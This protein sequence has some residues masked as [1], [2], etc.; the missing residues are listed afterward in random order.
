MFQ[1]DKQT[2]TLTFTP[3]VNLESPIN[4]HVFEEWKE[5]GVPGGNPGRHGENVQTPH[6]TAGYQ[7]HDPL[8]VTWKDLDSNPGP[9][10]CEAT[11]LTSKPP[12]FLK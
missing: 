4:L 3:T 5:A 12:C 11:M 2:S 6:R 1:R 7:S 8:D 10:C 9:S